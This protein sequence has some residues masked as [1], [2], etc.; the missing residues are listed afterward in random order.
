[1]TDPADVCTDAAE[2]LAPHFAL[3]IKTISVFLVTLVL[4]FTQLYFT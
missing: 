2:A 4:I 3:S 1:M